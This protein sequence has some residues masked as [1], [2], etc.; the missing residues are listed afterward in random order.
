MRCSFHLISFLIL[1]K[2]LP[3]G[4]LRGQ[5]NPDGPGLYLRELNVIIK[6]G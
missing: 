4:K 1:K 6:N 3:S 5:L 2:S